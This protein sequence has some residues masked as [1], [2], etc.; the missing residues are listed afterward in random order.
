[1]AHIIG[2]ICLFADKNNVA[3]HSQLLGAI[4]ACRT[5]RPVADHH[6]P[7]VYTS[8]A[9]LCEYLDAVG[10]AFYG[11]EIRYMNQKPFAV[12]RE[13][14]MERRIGQTF[15]VILADKIGYDLDLVKI[16]S[17]DR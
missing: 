9:N 14:R 6:E 5:F 15:I 4:Y 11:P 13:L 16:K 3:V 17:L 2:D 1:N 12:W 7:G 8:G 10:R